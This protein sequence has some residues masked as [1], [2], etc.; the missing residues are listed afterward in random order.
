MF[1]FRCDYLI[2]EGA[3]EGVVDCVFLCA[4]LYL[5]VC[6]RFLCVCFCSVFLL[7]IFIFFFSFS[8]SFSFGISCIFRVELCLSLCVCLSFSVGVF[9]WAFFFLIFFWVCFRGLVLYVVWA[10]KLC[11]SWFVDFSVFYYYVL[12]S[13]L[14]LWVHSV[15][16]LHWIV[17]YYFFCNL[18]YQLL[19][20]VWCFFCISYYY[21]GFI[22]DWYDGL[23]DYVVPWLCCHYT[24]FLTI[25]FFFCIAMPWSIWFVDIF[26]MLI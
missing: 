12:R 21:I 9:L 15:P 17:K 22:F 24:L 10:S 18:G 19:A 7:F 2:C 20:F 1:S 11:G 25:Y 14:L 4:S 16:T 3:L 13:E 8:F 23:D 26:H 5:C 6:V